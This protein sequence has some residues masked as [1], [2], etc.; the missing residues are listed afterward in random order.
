MLIFI[1]GS[2]TTAKNWGGEKVSTDRWMVKLTVVWPMLWNTTQHQRNVPLIQGE[3]ISEALCWVRDAKRMSPLTWTQTNPLWQKPVLWLPGAGGGRER[4]TLKEL[5]ESLGDDGL[6]PMDLFCIRIV[7]VV[8]WAH[9]TVKTHQI[10]H[11]TCRLWGKKLIP[12]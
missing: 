1:I 9:A 10:V 11:F 3:W 6:V 12:Q 5:K 4:W 8:S 7:A 2:F